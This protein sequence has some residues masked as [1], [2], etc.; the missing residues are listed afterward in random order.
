MTVK[1]ALKFIVPRVLQ[2]QFYCFLWSN[3]LHEVKK[4]ILALFPSHSLFFFFSSL[5]DPFVIRY[6]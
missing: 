5:T 2:A 3:L 1:R 4:M 6:F